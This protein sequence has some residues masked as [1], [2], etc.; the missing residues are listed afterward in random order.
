MRG[1]EAW[2]R[3]GAQQDTRKQEKFQSRIE[4]GAS[5]G[6]RQRNRW[7]R[8][9]LGLTFSHLW[10]YQLPCEYPRITDSEFVKEESDAF[11]TEF[12]FLVVD[13]LAF[14]SGHMSI[15]LIFKS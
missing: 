4:D 9:C 1:A 2:K 8:N 6:K 14:K 10:Q 15:Y 3:G 7:S 13:T 5:L 11:N 12:P